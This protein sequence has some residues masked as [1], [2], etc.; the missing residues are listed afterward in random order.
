MLYNLETITS[1]M[2]APGSTFFKDNLYRRLA[3]GDEVYRRGLDTQR[4][5]N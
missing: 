5:K 1:I 2:D 3:V 4:E